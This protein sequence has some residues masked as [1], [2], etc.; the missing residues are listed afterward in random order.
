[1]GAF[2]PQ[3]RRISP[4]A[5]TGSTIC[6]PRLQERRHQLA[7]TMSGGE[8]QMCAIG[9]ALMSKPKLLL[10]DE[11][12]AGLAPLVVAAGVRSCPP[13]PRRRVHRADCRAERAAGARPR[14]SRLSARGR[15]HPARGQR[16]RTQGQRLH[17]HAPIWDCRR[18]DGHLS[19]RSDHQRHSARRRAG[20]ACARAE[21]DLRRHRRGVD[22]LCRTRHVRHVR[23]LLAV[24]RFRL[25]V[26]CSPAWS[27]SSACAAAR[28][29]GSCADHRAGSRL[30]ADQPAAGHRRACC[31]FCR[32][33]PRC[34]FGTD[35][36]NL[37]VRLPIIEMRRHLH[38]LCALIG[39]RRSARRRRRALFLSQAHL[40][41]N[42]D[43]RHR[44]GPRNHGP[45][46]R[47]PAADL[48]HHLGDRR[49]RSPALRPACWCCNTTCTPSSATPSVRSSS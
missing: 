41:R 10:M 32:A 49:R 44:P 37:G 47:R 1:M 25:A 9:R 8:Q 18:S 31:S 38:Q 5:S 2:I 24:C 14:R 29:A 7:G 3:A 40:S 43:P 21:P 39:V 34:L 16:R 27:R 45:D 17:P 36:R 35:F 48:S 4:S 33:S 15:A 6:F 30:A 26:C 12:S 13:H 19:P 28:H 42:R 22:R 20:A 11:P 46:G 23:D